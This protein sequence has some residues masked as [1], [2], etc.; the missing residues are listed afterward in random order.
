MPFGIQNIGSTCYANSVIQCIHATPVL[1]RALDNYTGECL[2][3]RALRDVHVPTLLSEMTQFSTEPNDPHEFIL[4]LIDR[5]E[6]SLGKQLFYGIVSSK[7]IDSFGKVT[8]TKTEFSTLMF[9]DE[10]MDTEKPDYIMD[11]GIGKFSCTQLTY[12]SLPD[13]LMC[14]FV[15]PVHIKLPEEYKGKKLTGCVLYVPGHY[16]ACIRE[17][18]KWFLINDHHV[19]EIDCVPTAFIY[20]AV[21]NK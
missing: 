8:T 3:T 12:E 21:Y 20:I 2:V 14:L 4:A 16:L 5:L 19:S 1:K 17:G 15:K 7:F 11:T 9:H 18:D 13:V 6:K 10:N